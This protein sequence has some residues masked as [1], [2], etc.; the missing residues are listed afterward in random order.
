VTKK[1]NQTSQFQKS[2]YIYQINRLPAIHGKLES[3][4]KDP[5]FILPEV[6]KIRKS[7]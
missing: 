1:K 5:L 7:F 6:K 2:D 3:G 4:S